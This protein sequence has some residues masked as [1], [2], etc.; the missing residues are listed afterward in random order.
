MINHA[1]QG[2]TMPQ[3]ITFNI[4]LFLQQLPRVYSE[5]IISALLEQ[6]E[7]SV[8]TDLLAVIHT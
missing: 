8:S 4:K 1:S 2:V 3:D 7:R 6:T 5:N